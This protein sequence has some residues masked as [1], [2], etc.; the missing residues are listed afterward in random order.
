MRI[1]IWLSGFLAGAFMAL[2]F[3]LLLTTA[4]GGETESGDVLKWGYITPASKHTKGRVD[5]GQVS[6]ASSRPLPIDELLDKPG[7]SRA[8]FPRD[9]DISKFNSDSVSWP[10]FYL[11]R[12]AGSSVL[13]SILPNMKRRKVIWRFLNHEYELIILEHM[14]YSNIVSFNSYFRHRVKYDLKTGSLLVKKLQVEDS[15]LF[16]VKLAQLQTPLILQRPADISDRVQLSCIVQ[17]GKVTGT[18]W[19]KDGVP[20]HNHSQY[21]LA[22]DGSTL[23]IE[24][25]KTT[26]CGLYTCSVKND[27]SKAQISYFLVANGR[28]SHCIR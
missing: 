16:E 11:R 14:S 13:F 18:Q 17:T 28:I 1:Y 24:D 23:F 27:V 2:G 22:S 12:P 21:R 3:A 15:G 4:S 5:P 10:E 7:N 8:G 6:N 25:L 19:L 26:D 20:I 9:E